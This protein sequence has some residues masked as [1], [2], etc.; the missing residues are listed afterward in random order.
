[1]LQRLLKR[2]ETSGRV[3]DTI[4]SIMKRFKVQATT[5]QPVVQ[6]FASQGRVHNIDAAGTVEQVYAAV[7][8]V[9]AK[10]L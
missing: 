9:I 6:H 3:D 5:V 7:S 1:M 2:A 10:H 8:A 4:E